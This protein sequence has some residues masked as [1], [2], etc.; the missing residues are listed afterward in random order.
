MKY[1]KPLWTT[2]TEFFH[3]YENSEA[4]KASAKLGRY[5][6]S[7]S[8]YSEEKKGLSLMHF[9]HPKMQTQIS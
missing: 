2:L 7:R 1:L 9:C 5:L 3:K 6:N 8:L 4:L